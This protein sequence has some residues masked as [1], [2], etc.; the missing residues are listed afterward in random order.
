MLVTLFDKLGRSENVGFYLIA[1]ENTNMSGK[2]YAVP[3]ALND[4][5]KGNAGTITQKATN[6]KTINSIVA[7][8]I[9]TENHN[10]N[11]AQISTLQPLLPNAPSKAVKRCMKREVS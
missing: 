4:A 6:Q 5:V 11:T 10:L 9:G 3:G 8:V 7:E 1:T 2:L